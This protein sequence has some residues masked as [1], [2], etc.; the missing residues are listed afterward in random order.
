[1]KEEL[2]LDITFSETHSEWGRLERLKVRLTVLAF[3]HPANR[4]MVAMGAV[5]L[6]A[7][8]ACNEG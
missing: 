8:L 7:N 5:S 2:K 6:A 1:M 3:V 4:K